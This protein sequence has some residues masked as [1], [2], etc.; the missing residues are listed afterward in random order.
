MAMQADVDPHRLRPADPVDLALLDGTQQLRLQP[1]L[2]LADLVQQKRAAVGLL[3]LADP[4]GDRA[5]ERTL[6]MAEQ[7]GFEQ[8]LGDGGTVHG[9]EGRPGAAAVLVEKARHHLLAGAAL[10]GDQDAGVGRCEL[11]GQRQHVEHARV[12]GDELTAALAD[13]L[14]EGR[15]QVRIGRQGQELAGACP[16]R[17]H[18]Q[19]RLG[20]DA[21]GHDR[22]VDALGRH[23]VDQE[24]DILADVD[25]QQLGTLPL[26]QAAQRRLAVAH[27]AHL[28]TPRRRQATD[29][30]SSSGE[31]SPTISSRMAEGSSVGGLPTPQ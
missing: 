7:L 19:T 15:D 29:A 13:R 8:V 10:A 11:A 28:G 27:A 31:L 25:Q 16:D 2:H 21:I 1:R 20:V 5:R 4:A 3:E 9:D 17:R 30:L 18:G 26:A 22:Q 12:L 24:A 23:L 14:Q 6:L